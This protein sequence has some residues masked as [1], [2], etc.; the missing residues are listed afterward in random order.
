MLIWRL[1]RPVSWEL[2]T[3]YMTTSR[4]GQGDGFYCRYKGK[5]SQRESSRLKMGSGLSWAMREERGRW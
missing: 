2:Q 1:D 5:H 4:Y 3:E